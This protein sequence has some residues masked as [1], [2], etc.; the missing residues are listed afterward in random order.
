MKDKDRENIFENY[1][2]VGMQQMDEAGVDPSKP[3]GPNLGYTTAEAGAEMTLTQLANQIEADPSF[4][5]TGLAMLKKVHP[6]LSDLTPEA[7]V[8]LLHALSEVLGS[9]QVQNRQRSKWDTMRAHGVEG[10]TE[11]LPPEQLP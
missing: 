1:L 3:A 6:S 8:A 2:S 9:S 11:G 5:A 7:T 10:S 4:F